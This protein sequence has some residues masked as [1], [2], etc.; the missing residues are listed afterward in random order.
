[1]AAHCA[2]AAALGLDALCFT[3]HYDFDPQSLG[4]Y[5][6]DD[7]FAELGRL[8]AEYAGRLT[9]LA[10]LEF[11]EPHNHPREFEAMAAL[12]YDFLLGSIHY[13][14][15][16][17]FVGEMAARGMDPQLCYD[18]YWDQVRQ[19]VAFGGFDA[20]GHLDFPKR[21]FRKLL[22]DPAALDDIF[23]LMRKNRILLEV[24]SSSLRQGRDEP[25][26]G[27]ALLR[28]YISHGFTEITLG[29]DAH[30]AG[31][32]YRDVPAARALAASLGL[33]PVCLIERKRYALASEHR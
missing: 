21:Y 6:A 22:Y 27:E 14:L 16:G 17:L 25:M 23:A 4:H 30:T 33:V 32:L 29:S 3:E 24:N 18:A 19:M 5:H 7:F 2:R 8:R 10:G 31:D 11:S 26:P 12:P 9:L 13:Y 28:Q 1:M 15:G 20:V